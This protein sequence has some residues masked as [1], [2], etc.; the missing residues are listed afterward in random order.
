[1]KPQDVKSKEEL[2]MLKRRVLVLENSMFGKGGYNGLKL[3]MAQKKFNQKEK[4]LLKRIDAKIK[5]N[6]YH[7]KAEKF[8]K[9][10]AKIFLQETG[11]VEK[12]I[13]LLTKDGSAICNDISDIIRKY[14]IL[15]DIEKDFEILDSFDGSAEKMND[16][17]FIRISKLKKDKT[18]VSKC[19]TL[20]RYI[21]P[22]IKFLNK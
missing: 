10:I 15:Y 19:D 20:M 14:Y 1:M 13:E 17:I 3:K 21:Q 7:H 9:E 2:T 16:Y 11:S 18:F 8:K 4:N 22:I 12:S 5:I 6:H